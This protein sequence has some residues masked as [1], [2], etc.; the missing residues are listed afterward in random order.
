MACVRKATPGRLA[1]LTLPARTTTGREEMPD[2]AVRDC[3]ATDG[4]DRIQDRLEGL[5]YTSEIR[6]YAEAAE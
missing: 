2:E 1:N 4:L 5:P 3:P 6:V